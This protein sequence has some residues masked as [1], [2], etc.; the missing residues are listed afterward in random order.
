MDFQNYFLYRKNIFYGL[1]YF[2]TFLFSPKPL[3]NVASVKSFLRKYEILIVVILTLICIYTFA[4]FN[5]KID[6]FLGNDL[7]VNL[8]PSRSFFSMHYGDTSRVDFNVSMENVAYCR[9]SCSYEF[10]DR[11]R[12]ILIDK[13]SFEISI[14][15]HFSRS[16]NLSVKRLGSGQ[17][18]Y[19]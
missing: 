18:L 6:F 11:S 17:D 15:R 4:F 16:Y 19:S 2:K 5:Q 14:G 13:N 12:N 9:A 8:N 10:I 3:K 7:I 1:H